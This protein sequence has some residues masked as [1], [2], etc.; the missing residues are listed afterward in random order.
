[1]ISFRLSAN[2][3]IFIDEYYILILLFT[4]IDFIFIRRIKNSRK[5]KR[6]QVEELQKLK[7]ELKKLEKN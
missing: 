4:L 5:Q 6:L 7:I 3:I 1:M 2:R